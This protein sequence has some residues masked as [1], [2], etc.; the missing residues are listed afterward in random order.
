MDLEKNRMPELNYNCFVP[1]KEIVFYPY[2][3]NKQT[4]NNNKVQ[5]EQQI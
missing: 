1:L 5:R 3:N 4:N 2:K